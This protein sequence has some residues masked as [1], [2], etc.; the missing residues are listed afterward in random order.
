MKGEDLGMLKMLQIPRA[1]IEHSKIRY[2]LSNTI[3]SFC[4]E[5]KQA[6][7]IHCVLGLP[8]SDIANFTELSQKHV[9]DVLGLYSERLASKLHIFQRSAPYNPNDVL[10]VSE[11]LFMEDEVG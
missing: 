3:E 1:F 9:V 10:P 7:Y 2:A 5:E 6:I 11:L 4:P 8:I